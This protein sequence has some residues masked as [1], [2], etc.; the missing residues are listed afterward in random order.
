MFLLQVQ[1]RSQLVIF[2]LGRSELV[3]I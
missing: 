3:C 2:E 1:V